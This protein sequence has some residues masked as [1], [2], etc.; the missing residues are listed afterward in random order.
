VPEDAAV[1]LR[2]GVT[3]LGRRLRAERV[4]GGLTA[5]EL[6]VLGH[7]T[8]RGPLTPGDL[9]AAD[10]LQPQSLTRALVRLEADQLVARSADPADGR[11]SLLTITADG[12]EALRAA[13]A[14]RDAWLDHVMTAELT[15]TEIELL[16]LAGGLME[17]LSMV[18]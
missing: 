17:R 8:R 2:R 15:P 5:L 6:S 4:P 11:R 9:A 16:C 18:R 3:S 1:T 7:L 14:E 12:S 13:M 10:R